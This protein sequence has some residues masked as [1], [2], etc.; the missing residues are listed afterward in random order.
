MKKKINNYMVLIASILVI[1][2]LNMFIRTVDSYIDLFVYFIPA[3]LG[4]LIFF[5][6]YNLFN[7]KNKKIFKIL[8]CTTLGGLI[9]ILWTRYIDYYDSWKTNTMSDLGNYILPTIVL[10]LSYFAQRILCIIFVVKLYRKN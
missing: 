1:I 7:D 4:Y 10:F 3:F 8:V 2:P 6:Q 5:S 9:S